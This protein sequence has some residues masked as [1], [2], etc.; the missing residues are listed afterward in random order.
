MEDRTSQRVDMPSAMVASI[1]GPVT[2]PMVL[3]LDTACLALSYPTRKALFFD[4]LSKR[5]P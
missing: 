4:I 5:H 2:D 1:G 3:T